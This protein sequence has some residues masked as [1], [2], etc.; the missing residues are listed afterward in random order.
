MTRPDALSGLE[1]G[2]RED[3]LGILMS[4]RKVRAGAIRDFYN[5]PG[6][7]IVADLLIDLEVDDDARAEFID[8]LRRQNQRSA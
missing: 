8:A 6:G 4:P 5:R 2:V 1:P 3:L 7:Q